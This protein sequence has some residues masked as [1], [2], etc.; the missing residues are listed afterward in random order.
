MHVTL[1]LETS[2]P[3]P[4]TLCPLP[5]QTIT[6]FLFSKFIETIIVKFKGFA[7]EASSNNQ[8]D[9]VKYI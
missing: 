2:T 3:S 8:I 4:P 7:I 9:F 1:S 5:L 6:T